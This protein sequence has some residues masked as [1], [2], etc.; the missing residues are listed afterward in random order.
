M[1]GDFEKWASRLRFVRGE[2]PFGPIKQIRN[3]EGRL[4]CDNAPA[5]VSPTFCSWFKDGRRHGLHVDIWGTIIY[6]YEGIA[7]PRKYILEPGSITVE[8]VFKEKNAEVRYVGVKVLGFDKI[9]TSKRYKFIHHDP[10]KN[11]DLFSIS[12]V[13]DEPMV[14]VKVVNNSPEPD[15]SYKNYFLQVPPTM[16]TCQEAVAWTFRKTVKD[17]NP[18]V[19][20]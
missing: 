10:E 13:F 12:G 1:T 2:Y 3:A 7:V 16:R 5:S 19:E 17:Y 6:F 15:G 14:V 11:S 9:K 18:S 4:H 8:D 20:A